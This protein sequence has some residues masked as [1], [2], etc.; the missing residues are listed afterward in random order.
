MKKAKF[1][2][3]LSTISILGM[4]FSCS[5]QSK[6]TENNDIIHDDNG[7]VVYDKVELKLWSVTTGDDA[8][9]QNE[10][11]ENFNTI[12]DGMIHVS[13]EH[14]SRYDLESRLNSTMSFDKANAP[15]ALFTHGHRTREYIENKWIQP[16]EDYYTLSN[17]PLDKSDFAPSLLNTVTFEEKMYSTPIDV[18]S[19]MIEMRV[20]ILEKNNLSIPTNY[21]ELVSVCSKATELAKNGNLWIRG[22]NSEGYASDEWRKATT[23][24]AYTAFPISYGDMWVHEFFGYTAAIQNGGAF[25]AS[26]G[27]GMPGWDTDEVASGLQVL[28]D[29]IFPSS[30]SANK[31]QLS[32]DYGSGY[33]VGIEPFRSGKAIFKLN[34]PWVYKDDL[35]KFDIMLRND[36]GETNITTRSLSNMVAKDTSKDYASKIKG[37]GHAIMLMSTVESA[38]KKCAVS[39][40][41]DYMAYYSGIEWAKRG[42]IPA[43]NS[44]LNNNE[45]KSDDD[46]EKYIKYWGT[47]NDY[48][49]YGSTKYYSYIDTYF[50]QGLQKSIASQFQSKSIKE[51]LDNEYKDCKAY[52]ELYA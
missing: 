32:L 35:E 14:I 45:F 15:D 44:V 5:N 4:L 23:A 29:W 19:T 49:V 37:E 1:L 46:Y 38:T 3:I 34:G 22:E 8:S 50:K 24:E 11:I 28:R 42:H 31:V 36:G 48:E 26:D 18:H 13:A 39:V 10:I 40:F 27:T 6:V 7:N 12:Y 51:I 25:L 9:T 52:I 30:T 16:I 47:P 20:D 43:V 17:T 21:N 33:D 2:S 41:A